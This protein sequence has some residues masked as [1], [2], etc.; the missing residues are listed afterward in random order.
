[1]TLYPEVQAK[2]R[3]EIQ[4]VLGSDRLPGFQDRDN[5]PYIN[6]IVK[7]T[8]RWHATVPVIT[9]KSIAPDVCEGYDIPEGSWVMANVWFVLR[10]GNSTRNC[11]LLTYFFRAMNHDP[12]TYVDPFSFKPERFLGCEGRAPEPDPHTFGFGRRICPGRNLAR[13]NVYL[14]VAQSLAAF[15]ISKPKKNGTESGFRPEFQAGFVSSPAPYEIDIRV[16]S[17]A[18]ENL[19]R[20]VETEYPWEQSHSKEIKSLAS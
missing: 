2:A 7:E 9:H 10:M 20:T 6:A 17:P 5:L 11:S 16:R 12:K 8:L 1:M 13:A 15:Q 19:I 3:A 14:T 18:Y 4:S